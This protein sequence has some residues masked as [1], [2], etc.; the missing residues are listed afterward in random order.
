[1]IIPICMTK[2]KQIRFGSNHKNFSFLLLQPKILLFQFFISWKS[3]LSDCIPLM[4][5]HTMNWPKHKFIFIS[6]WL[7]FNYKLLYNVNSKLIILLLIML[8]IKPLTYEYKW[9]TIWI[10]RNKLTEN[11]N[12]KFVPKINTAFFKKSMYKIFTLIHLF[13]NGKW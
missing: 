6:F 3:S 1:M 4:T 2:W 11:F 8:K 9:P 13:I 12:I 5:E 10:Y 7:S